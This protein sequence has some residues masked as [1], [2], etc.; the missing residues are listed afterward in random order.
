MKKH[1]RIAITLDDR[2]LDAASLSLWL[3]LID[4]LAQLADREVAVCLASGVN[5]K[6]EEWHLLRGENNWASPTADE[7]FVFLNSSTRLNHRLF[8]R[9]S[10]LHLAPHEAPSQ[11]DTFLHALLLN[12]ALANSSLQRVAAA[13]AMSVSSLPAADIDVTLISSVF[14]GDEFLD[15]FLEN[16]CELQ[17][18]ARQEHFLVRA[19]SPGNEHETI[20]RHVES[21]P[22]AIYINLAEDPGLY[23]VWN[24]CATLASGR[25]LTNAN[26]DDRRAPQHLGELTALLDAKP[27]LAMASSGLRVGEMPNLRWEESRGLAEWFTDDVPERFSARDL[28]IQQQGGNFRSRNLPHCMPV[29]R[30]ELHARHGMFDEMQFGPSAD[31]EFWL[32]CGVRGE[33]FG[34]VPRALGLFLRSPSSY[35]QSGSS[36]GSFD[37][38][39][40]AHYLPL[41]DLGPAKPVEANKEDRPGAVDEELQFLK[42]CTARFELACRI[43]GLEIEVG[44]SSQ[45]DESRRA[46]AREVFGSRIGDCLLA[47]QTFGLAVGESWWVPLLDEISRGGFASAE[48]FEWQVLVELL[49]DWWATTRDVRAMLLQ[50]LAWRW[51]GNAGMEARCLLVAYAVRSAEFWRDFQQVYRFGRPLHEIVRLVCPK[52][53]LDDDPSIWASTGLVFYPDYRHGNAYQ[54]F[55]Y[56]GIQEQGASISGLPGNTWPLQLAR[57]K[58]C[59]SVFH[60]HWLNPV[61]NAPDAA[62]RADEL[63]ARVREMR[64]GGTEVYWTIHNALTHESHFPAIER[65]LRRALAAEVD[66]VYLHHPLVCE[67]VEW[68]P[69]DARLYLTEHGPYSEPPGNAQSRAALRQQ[70]GVN[71]NDTLLVAFGMVKRYKEL[72]KL[73]PAIRAAMEHD[74]HLKLMVAGRQAYPGIRQAIAELPREQVISCDTFVPESD[75][76]RILH[77]GDYAL[78]S[79]GAILTSGSMFQAFSAGLPVIA[80]R[81]GTLPAYVVPA[82]NGFLYSDAAEF[83]ELLKGLPRDVAARE[84]LGQNAR[85]AADS[86]T[87]KFP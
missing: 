48:P 58:G 4:D 84:R 29:W 31:W 63:L 5:V 38:R 19:A 15:G 67:L 1:N 62:R 76:S 86:L 82:W 11:I 55:L 22:S 32:R 17:G 46:L 52:I 77:A 69:D 47:R 13:Q 24:L 20:W 7:E 51:R 57:Q 14:S 74:S 79:Y 65:W 72:E 25:Y 73:L 36:K 61:V 6:S 37:E 87:W 64:R 16:M 8:A 34:H 75:L 81:K 85:Y 49:A 18:Y 45:K 50:A 80:P 68:L 60:L 33:H 71:E 10:R 54:S 12:D 27:E 30:R 28:V 53:R 78:L 21:C 66:R 26:I 42:S 35:W 40:L 59:R 43:A 56:E 41:L 3:A 23:G 70:F 83:A 39:I 2:R 9:F 44:T